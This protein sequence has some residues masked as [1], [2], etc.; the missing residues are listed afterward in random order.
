MSR[1]RPPLPGGA[2]PRVRVLFRP[3]R[4]RLSVRR[5]QGRRHAR[6]DRRRA[7]E[8]VAIQGAPADRRRRCGRPPRGLHSAASRAE[9]RRRARVPRDLGEERLGL[10]PDVVVQ[11]SRGV[12]RGHEGARVR[13]RHGGVRLDRKPRE[14]RRRPRRRGPAE[15]VHLHPGRSR[16]GQGA[17]D[18]GLQPDPGRGSRHLR[19]GEPALLGDRRQVPLGVRER[20][21]SAVLLRGIEELRVRD[22]RAARL[23]DARARHRADAPAAR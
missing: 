14:L 20:E 4:G 2:H 9:P 11:G 7:A 17:R 1:V 16:A 15:V 10:P 23:A 18:P 3:P 22:R 6:V 13:L 19:R 5:A 12:G 21:F 8:H